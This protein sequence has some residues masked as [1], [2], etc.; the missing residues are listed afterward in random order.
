[1][2]LTEDF[3]KKNGFVL[4]FTF[5]EKNEYL[6]ELPQEN[7]DINYLW[8]DYYIHEDECMVLYQDL[9]YSINKKVEQLQGALRQ[10]F[11]IEKNFVL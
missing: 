4:Q 1:M 7:G 2:V 6:L 11:N 3:L 5:P 8:V 9:C 10:K